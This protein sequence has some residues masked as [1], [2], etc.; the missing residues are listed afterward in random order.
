MDR[1]AV[2]VRRVQV[3]DA[4]RVASFVNRALHG[5]VEIR[6]RRVIERLG[7]VGFLLAERN[8]VLL[9]LIGWQVENLVACVTD[10][11][12]WPARERERVGRGLLSE[13][14]KGAVE[15]Q[16]EAA[17]LLLPPSRLSELLP[18]CESF[19]YE[20][21]TVADLPGAWREIAQQAGLDDRDE[22]PV[23]ELRADRV[24]R[25]L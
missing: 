22:I 10:L 1:Q 12:I 3:D 18:F 4:E 9:G 11:L 25:P 15:L 24:A 21:R 6:P 5:R 20:L 2:I 23:K 17:L 16:A 14:E 7:D 8:D 13:M 19:G